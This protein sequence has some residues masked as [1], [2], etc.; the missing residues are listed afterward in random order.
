MKD[1]FS[2]REV[3]EKLGCSE[4]TIY[5]LIGDGEIIAFK[6]RGSLRVTGESLDEYRQRQIL[7]YRLVNE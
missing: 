1:N 7:S 2:I 3:A 4:R 6:V 5:R